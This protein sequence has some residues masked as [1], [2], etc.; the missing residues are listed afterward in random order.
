MLLDLDSPSWSDELLDSVLRRPGAVA[1][2]GRRPRSTGRGSCSASR[3]RSP[4]SPATSRP[5]SSATALPSR[6]EAKAT[7]GTGSFMLRM[8]EPKAGGVTGATS[9]D[10]RRVRRLRPRRV[11]SSPA[12]RS[13]GCATGS[14]SSPTRRTRTSTGQVPDERRGVSLVPAFAGLGSPHWN[15]EARGRS[16][17]SRA[18]RPAH[19]RARRSRGSRSRSRTCW[20]AMSGPGGWRNCGQTAARARTAS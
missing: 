13:S 10:G 3:C 1:A 8:Q 17:G 5:R 4:G 19:A 11:S 16:A 18:G 7:Y 6:G 20:T 9:Y 15:A 2:V 14:G 12:P